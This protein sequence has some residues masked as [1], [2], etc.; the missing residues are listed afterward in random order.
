MSYDEAFPFDASV[1]GVMVMK[2][3]RVWPP[4]LFGNDAL[5]ADPAPV[6]GDSHGRLS[7]TGVS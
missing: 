2:P 1:D 4:P 7:T 6:A 3:D 5:A